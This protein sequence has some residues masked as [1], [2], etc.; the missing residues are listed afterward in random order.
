MRLNW[1]PWKFIIR[2]IAKNQGFLDPV[3]LLSQFNKF[4]QPSEVAAPVELLRAG[5]IFHARGLINARTIQNN[6]DWIWPNWVQRQFNPLDKAFIPRSFSLTHVNITSRNWTAVGLP[7]CAAFPIV[8]SHG[9]ITPFYDGWSI[10]GWILLP[11]GKNLL[12]PFVQS[13]WQ[14]LMF[15]EDSLWIET[16][17]K[18]GGMSIH[19]SVDV[20]MEE[21]EAVCRTKYRA[22]S[23]EAGFFVVALRPFNPEGVSFVHTLSCDNKKTRWI[24][25]EGEHVLFDTPIDRHVVS[26]YR[27]G[28]VFQNLL[29]RETR[30][31]RKCDVGLI[32]AAAIYKLPRGQDREFTVR[33]PLA[34]DPETPQIFPAADPQPQW[35]SAL[36]SRCRIQIPDKQMEFLFDAAIRAIILHSP[37]DTYPGPFYYKCFWFRDAVFIVHTLLCIGLHKRAERI[38][39]Q[40]IPRQTLTGYFESQYGEWDSNGQ[41]LW[42]FHRF[43][44]LTGNPCKYDWMKALVKGGKWLRRKRTSST[45]DKP[46]AGLLPAGFSAEHLGNNDYYYWDDL[47]GAAGLAAAAEL[48]R[49]TGDQQNAEA[50]QRESEHFMLCIERSLLRSR[51]IRKYDGFPASPYRRMDAGS[52]GSIIISYPLQL[53]SPQEPR[54]INTLQFLLDQCFIEQAFFQDITHSGLNNYLSLHCAQ[55]FLRAGDDRFLPIVERAA[56]LASPT[57]QWPEAIHPQT[58]GGCM[59]DGQH[60]WAAAEWVMMLRNMFVREEEEGLILF[61]GIPQKWFKEQ[62]EIQMGPV[63]TK[64]GPITVKAEIKDNG[65][66]GKWDAE[67]RRSPAQLSLQFMGY[68]PVSIPAPESKGSIFVKLQPA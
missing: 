6:L 36:E 68:K 12:G 22:R 21:G 66:W 41:V 55:C 54:L 8:D 4:A 56:E 27:E 52:V 60:I 40:F 35:S 33:I 58:L 50:F 51:E 16:I 17:L 24:V 1:L 39:N 49:Q 67:W 14:K 19:S 18:Y 44:Q 26:C 47:W 65:I 31:S 61:S 59:G 10:D 63:H 25:N 48:C 15:N 11:S 32:S 30:T 62:E 38:I 45:I 9:L 28:D 64:F 57:G 42:L 23:E 3:A 46:H 7:D 20:L 53:C 29:S 43:H 37:L 13:P 2:R 5:L 34:K